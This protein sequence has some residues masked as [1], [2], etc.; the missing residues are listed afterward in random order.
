MTADCD[1]ISAV[2]FDADEDANDDADDDDDDDDDDADDD[3]AVSA[4]A[5]VCPPDSCCLQM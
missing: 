3:E 1:L 2:S 5:S 4:E